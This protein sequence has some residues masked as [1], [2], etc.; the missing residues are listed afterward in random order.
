MKK[1][2]SIVTTVLVFGSS[3]LLAE[4]H[5]YAYLGASIINIQN[6]NIGYNGAS[7]IDLQNAI[8]QIANIGNNA[9]NY[10]TSSNDTQDT[11]GQAVNIGYGGDKIW[12]NNAMVGLSVEF[13]VGKIDVPKNSTAES[14]FLGVSADVKAGYVPVRDL[15]TYGIA[16]T[17]RQSVGN[18]QGSGFGY[19]AG[20][21]YAITNDFTISVEHKIYFMTNENGL[22]NY[23]TS[24]VNIK[25]TSLKFSN[26]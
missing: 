18:V 15:I 26:Y 19:G 13:Q 14:S 25:F 16:T 17:L 3:A 4:S 22:Y 7:A 5:K 9:P 21:D 2:L 20:I 1:V 8:G 12:G 11:T 24:G 6:V 23:S 10:D